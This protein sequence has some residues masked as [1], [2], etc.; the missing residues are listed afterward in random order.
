MGKFNQLPV[1]FE[2]RR[3]S[4]PDHHAVRAPKI[5]EKSSARE[6]F[7]APGHLMRGTYTNVKPF[8]GCPP[9]LRNEAD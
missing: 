7:F 8:R 6:G 9:R 1:N 5:W 2:T 3:L 4:Y